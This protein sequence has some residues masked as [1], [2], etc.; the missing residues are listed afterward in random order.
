[1]KTLDSFYA[2][3]ETI[4]SEIVNYPEN[5]IPV[6]D[7]SLGLKFVIEYHSLDSLSYPKSSYFVLASIYDFKKAKWVKDRDSLQNGE[8]DKFQRFFEDSILTKVVDRYRTKVPDS[9]VFV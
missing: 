3:R 8:L 9:L 7:S 2:N 1:M 4:T 6:T 5:F